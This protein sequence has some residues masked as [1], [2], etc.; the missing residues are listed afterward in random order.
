AIGI[1]EQLRVFGDDYNTPDGTAIRDYIHVVDL[2]KAHVI[3]VDRMIKKK[4]KKDFEI[5]NLGTGNGFS[6]LEVIKSFEKVTGEK[7]N[8][9][10]VDRRLGDVEQ[11]WADTKFANDELGWKAEKD[12][13]EMTLSAWKWELALKNLHT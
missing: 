3:A 8:Y 1:R 9:K 6:V 4:N 12:L 5:F 10:I 7:L 2:A 11:V 13:D